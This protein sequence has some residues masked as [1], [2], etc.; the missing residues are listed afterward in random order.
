MHNATPNKEKCHGNQA[1]RQRRRN[2]DSSKE[3]QVGG[4]KGMGQMQQRR[5]SRKM[6]LNNAHSEINAGENE[7]TPPEEIIRKIFKNPMT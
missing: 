2:K 3:K 6:T 7:K 1:N 5:H 4:E